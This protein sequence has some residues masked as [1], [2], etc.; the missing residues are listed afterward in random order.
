MLR[1]LSHMCPAGVSMELKHQRTKS[2]A[3]ELL[4]GLKKEPF[5][6]RQSI[7]Y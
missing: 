3:E 7:C 4:E 6:A 2:R 1:R 5:P